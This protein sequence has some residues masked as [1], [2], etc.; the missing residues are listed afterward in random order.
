MV[1]PARLRGDFFPFQPLQGEGTCALS[2]SGGSSSHPWGC[3]RPPLEQ[4]RA[5]TVPPGVP[6]GS[7][8]GPSPPPGA[9]MGTEELWWPG[10][11]RAGKAPGFCLWGGRTPAGPGCAVLPQPRSLQVTQGWGCCSSLRDRLGTSSPSPWQGLWGPRSSPKVGAVP[12]ASHPRWHCT[13]PTAPFAG[14]NA[15]HRS[16]CQPRSPLP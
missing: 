8:P 16:L 12:R 4:P 5:S 14:G 3:D 6:G 9:G 11:R 1:T 2:I 13:D 7:K 10:T 15:P